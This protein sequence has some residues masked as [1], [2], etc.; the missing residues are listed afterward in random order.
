MLS[1]LRGEGAR[2]SE[3]DLQREMER[4]GLRWPDVVSERLARWSALDRRLTDHLRLASVEASKSGSTGIAFF[5][6]R[7]AMC[8]KESKAS[9]VEESTGWQPNLAIWE[10]GWAAFFFLCAAC[11]VVAEG[12]P[13]ADDAEKARV[14]SLVEEYLEWAGE[15]E[16]EGVEC[17]RVPIEALR[18]GISDMA[19][20]RRGVPK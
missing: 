10:R 16:R 7:C 6:M 18:R 14:V 1:N 12:E 13:P 5:P 17:K 8:R 4:L 2:V 19:H 9:S 3:D 11:R 15:P 20:R